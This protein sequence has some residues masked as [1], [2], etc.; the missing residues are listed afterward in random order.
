MIL[1]HLILIKNPTSW[2][3]F[4]LAAEELLLRRFRDQCGAEAQSTGVTLVVPASLGSVSSPGSGVC[5]G[6]PRAPGPVPS[7]RSLALGPSSH[8]HPLY[9]GP[10]IQSPMQTCPIW[11]EWLLPLLSVVHP[12]PTAPA[13]QHQTA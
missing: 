2:V 3:G 10:N 9:P 5:P 11:L 6:R 7:P 13:P 1:S 4:P 12:H 8:V